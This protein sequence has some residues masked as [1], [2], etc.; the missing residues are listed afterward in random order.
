MQTYTNTTLTFESRLFIMVILDGPA[1]SN[2]SL[3]VVFG[4]E[5]SCNTVGQLT[6]FTIMAC[7]NASRDSAK[8]KKK[9]KLNRSCKLEMNDFKNYLTTMSGTKILPA[10]VFSQFSH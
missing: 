8:E 9:T 10:F 6:L 7:S 3:S 5:S 2:T 4:S 1:C